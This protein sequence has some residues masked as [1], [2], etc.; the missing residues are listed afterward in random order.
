VP[1][2]I[3]SRNFLLSRLLSKNLK[4]KIYM[5]V[6]LYMVLCWGETMSI[7]LGGG[8]GKDAAED[9]VELIRLN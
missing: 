9:N 7:E 1:S 3:Q 6:I 4:I 8:G 5:T 2:A